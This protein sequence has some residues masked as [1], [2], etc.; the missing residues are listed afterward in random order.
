MSN[1]RNVHVACRLLG[2]LTGGPQCRLS[3]LRNGPCHVTNIFSHV[4]GLHVECRF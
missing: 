4:D 2:P 1:L 3:V